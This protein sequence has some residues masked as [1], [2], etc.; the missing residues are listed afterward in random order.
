MT[1]PRKAGGGDRDWTV[2]EVSADE[3]PWRCDGGAVT[4]ARQAASEDKRERRRSHHT[5]HIIDNY[6][7]GMAE[8]DTISM[9]GMGAW[10][11]GRWWCA[12]GICAPPGFQFLAACCDGENRIR[13]TSNRR[14]WV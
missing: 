11:A 9:D 8:D 3:S 6:A 5:Q 12:R 4:V 13:V 1:P 10:G 7:D 14:V 2:G